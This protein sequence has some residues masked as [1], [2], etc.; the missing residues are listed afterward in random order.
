MGTVAAGEQ[1][2]QNFAASALEQLM[3]DFDEDIKRIDSE[4]ESKAFIHMASM[5]TLSRA[6]WLCPGRPCSSVVDML[7]RQGENRRETFVE[8]TVVER[9]RQVN[10]QIC[11]D[12]FDEDED[13]YVTPSPVSFEEQDRPVQ[14]E[15]K[16][17]KT[18]S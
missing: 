1:A 11:I 9:K 4:G 6:S 15:R 18:H 8:R 3:N 17:W 14:Q 10:L 16:R 13:R 2:A 7:V 5:P 12:E